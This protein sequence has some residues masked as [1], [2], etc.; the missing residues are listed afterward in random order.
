MVTAI[1]RQGQNGT[2]AKTRREIL[3]RFWLYCRP[4][5]PIRAVLICVW[6]FGYSLLFLP[7]ALLRPFHPDNSYLYCKYLTKIGL[8]ILGIEI[9]HRNESRFVGSRPCIFLLNHQHLI[10]TF[11]IGDI[12]PRRTVTVGK[13][14]LIWLPIFGWIFWL[15]GNLL[16]NRGKREKAVATLREAERLI[17]EKGLSV[18][19]APEGTRSGK[20]GL[21]P[22]K[23]GA[24]HLAQET[25]LQL[26]P[27]AI[28]TFSVLN[29]WKWK[30]GRVVIEALEPIP[31][32][33]KSIETMMAETH[34]AISRA[35]ERL[36]AEVQ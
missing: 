4:M 11:V 24:F 12:M 17:K 25:G 1:K 35:I 19:I 22:F 14:S 27:I 28:S 6:F 20:K 9:E 26:Q 21:G 8:W 18:I 32:L 31:T 5:Y 30:A 13:N 3:L 33:N 34:V 29:Y 23:R 10:D 15:S 16:I 36:N 7:V 2:L